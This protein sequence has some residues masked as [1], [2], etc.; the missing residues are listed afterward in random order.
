MTSL[1]EKLPIPP[2]SPQLIELIASGRGKAVEQLAYKVLSEAGYAEKLK[3][4]PVAIL[5]KLTSQPLPSDF[6]VHVHQSGSGVIHLVLPPAQ[7]EV[8]AQFANTNELTDE[9]LERIAGGTDPLTTAI[10]SAIVLTILTASAVVSTLTVNTA[11]LVSAS[12]LVSN[13]VSAVVTEKDHK[14]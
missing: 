8:Q 1:A 11:T 13:I 9:E 14:W 12:A 6:S 10:G 4:D 5:Q 7:E 3:A 2:L